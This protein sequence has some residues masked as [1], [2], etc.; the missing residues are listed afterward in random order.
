MSSHTAALY[1][2][3]G[4]AVLAEYDI[5]VEAATLTPRSSVTLPASIQYC[6]PSADRKILYIA[7]SSSASGYGPKG[8]DHHISAYR[9]DA[10]D[11]RAQ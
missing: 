3:A 2:D 5:D 11:R 10:P 6:W 1:P 9:I 8:T 7:T 4:P